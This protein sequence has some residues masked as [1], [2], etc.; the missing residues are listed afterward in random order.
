M[1]ALKLFWWIGQILNETTFERFM[2]L[3]V[4]ESFGQLA[5]IRD[6]EL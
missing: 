1:F 5:V 2:K 6:L 4:R 3:A